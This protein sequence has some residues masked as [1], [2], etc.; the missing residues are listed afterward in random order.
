[1]LRSSTT[2]WRVLNR[3]ATHRPGIVMDSFRALVCTSTITHTTTPVVCICIV[4]GVGHRRSLP[5]SCCATILPRMTALSKI[6]AT[7]CQLSS[8]TTSSIVPAKRSICN[9][10]R[11]RKSPTISSSAMPVTLPAVAGE[12]TIRICSLASR[13][14]A[15]RTGSAPIHCLSI[16]VRAWMA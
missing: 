14:L 5:P 4:T 1:M 8:L 9:S 11:I 7:V 12:H 13:A 3:L 15:T 2:K 10:A 6:L 16:P